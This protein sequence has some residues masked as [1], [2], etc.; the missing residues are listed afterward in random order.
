MKLAQIVAT[1]LAVLC[2]HCGEVQPDPASGSD[3]WLPEQIR[4]IQ[5]RKI[6]VSC[7]EPFILPENVTGFRQVDLLWTLADSRLAEREGWNVFDSGAH[8]LQIQKDDVRNVF[9]SDDTALAHCIRM[10]DISP[11]HARALA[12][13]Y[14]N[15][16]T[17]EG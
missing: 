13:H 12:I 4:E 7:D 8:G 11:R 9:Y 5:G 16:A 15:L 2:P 17:R 1:T 6:C 10:A 3:Q 14:H